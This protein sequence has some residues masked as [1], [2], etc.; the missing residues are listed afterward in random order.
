[1]RSR[2]ELTNAVVEL[3]IR[4]EELLVRECIDSARQPHIGLGDGASLPLWQWVREMSRR[5]P[6]QS[7][8]RPTPQQATKAAIHALRTIPTVGHGPGPAALAAARGGLLQQLGLSGTRQNVQGLSTRPQLER[9]SEAHRAREHHGDERVEQRNELRM[10]R[11][12]RQSANELAIQREVQ[13]HN[14]VVGQ[15][16]APDAEF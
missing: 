16:D 5:S 10:C 9:V 1:M 11:A 3:R 15:Q 12:A 14:A 13:A 4:G 6:L 8:D 7:H 2:V